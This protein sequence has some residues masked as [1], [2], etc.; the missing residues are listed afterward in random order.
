MAC[1]VKSYNKK[2]GITYV[3]S[4][5]SVWDPVAKT[6]RPQRRLIG[7]LNAEGEIVPTGKPGRPRKVKTEVSE[8]ANSASTEAEE[9]ATPTYTEFKLVLAELEET[10]DLLRKQEARNKSLDE[11][12]RRLKFQ[13]KRLFPVISDAEGSLSELRT[14]CEEAKGPA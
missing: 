3:Y 8:D 6:S 1:I 12:V 5:V 14:I 11:E 2:S 9:T 13:I 7:K 10:R 4:S